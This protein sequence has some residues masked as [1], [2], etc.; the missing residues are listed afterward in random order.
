MKQFLL[1]CSL[2]FL[3]N[4]AKANQRT[5]SPTDTVVGQA[6]LVNQL[7]MAACKK[8]DLEVGS[9]AML[10]ATQAQAAFELALSE[11]IENGVTGIRQAAQRAKTAG[12]YEQLRANL[13]TAVALQLVK[14][15]RTATALYGRFSNTIATTSALTA[16]ETAFVESWG[17]ELCKRLTTLNEKGLFQGKTSA[18]RTELFH[19][20]YIASLATRGPQIMQLYG[21]AG[22]SDQVTH[23]LSKLVMDNM[24]QRCSQTL[25][26]LKK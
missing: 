10:S 23:V 9:V 7:A 13:P 14:T 11:A 6:Q 24:I 17:D 18:E 19:Q 26:L 12:A 5:V 21:P 2:L 25:M 15:C 22:N 1:V 4:S 20:E 8:M 3:C 16:L